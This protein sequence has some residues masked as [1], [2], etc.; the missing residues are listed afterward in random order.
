MGVLFPGALVTSGWIDV[1]LTRL[2]W[3]WRHVI[4]GFL[5]NVEL[6]GCVARLCSVRG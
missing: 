3:L 6:G 5:R 2:L 1:L 4:N